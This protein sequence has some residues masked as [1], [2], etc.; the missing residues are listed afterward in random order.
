MK[1]LNLFL[2]VFVIAF[3]FT[4]NKT[5]S[6]SW[7]PEPVK[8]PYIDAI[9]GTWISAPYEFMGSTNT[10]EVIYKMI[11]NG[12]F[13]EVDMKRTDNNGF[14]Y[15]GKEIITPSADGTFTGTYYD[16]L[17]K[18]RSNTYS[19]AIDGNKILLKGSSPVGNGTREIIIDGDIMIQNIAFTMNDKSG[20]EMPEQ[21]ITITYKKQK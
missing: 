1:K 8:S 14:T 15:E 12:Q 5:F 21:K 18:S 2:I 16:I 20:N 3:Q 7:L 19:T 13:L 10:D 4:S 9:T 6:Q 11:L 17:G